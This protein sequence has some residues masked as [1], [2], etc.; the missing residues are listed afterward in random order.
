MR[1][2]RDHGGV[3]DDGRITVPSNVDVQVIV[4]PDPSKE[5]QEA[6]ADA[7]LV[8]EEVDAVVVSYADR[9]RVAAA[10]VKLVS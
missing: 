7:R 6:L 8:F 2:L 1:E 10:A 4:A 3:L 9:E 5:G